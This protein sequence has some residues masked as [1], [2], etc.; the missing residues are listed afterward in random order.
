MIKLELSEEQLKHLLNNS[1]ID[2]DIR[3]L[4]DLVL[5]EHNEQVKK[6]RIKTR[7]I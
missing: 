2:S 4:F 5:L 7:T 3:E 6:R 1:S